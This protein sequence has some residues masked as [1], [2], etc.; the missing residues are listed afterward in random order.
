MKSNVLDPMVTLTD[1]TSVKPF[2]AVT[3][4]KTMN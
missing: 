3:H 1:R 2:D 4:P